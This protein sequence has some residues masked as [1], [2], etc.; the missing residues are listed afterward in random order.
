MAN[1]QIILG[2]ILIFKAVDHVFQYQLFCVCVCVCVCGGGGCYWVKVEKG[3][4]PIK[5]AEPMLCMWIRKG[6][7]LGIHHHFWKPGKYCCSVAA[8]TRSDDLKWKGWRSEGSSLANRA[9]EN[10]TYPLAESESQHQNVTDGGV[11]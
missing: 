6:Q 9:S 7:V 10:R 3:S 1:A 2:F 11:F 8:E 4:Y 5:H